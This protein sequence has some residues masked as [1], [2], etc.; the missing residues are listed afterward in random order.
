MEVHIPWIKITIP[1]FVYIVAIFFVLLKLV[2]KNNSSFKNNL[3]FK[4]IH[5]YLP[6][7][8]IVIAFLSYTFGYSA[9]LVI[10]SIFGEQPEKKLIALQKLKETNP[11]RYQSLNDTYTDFVM[12]R[13]LIVA[14][15]LLGFSL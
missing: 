1:G 9:H 15:I 8:A 11:L 14:S 3:C 4:N 7:I 12:F 6:Y 10:Q 5:Y 2:D 13:H